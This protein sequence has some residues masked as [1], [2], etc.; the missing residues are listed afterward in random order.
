MDTLATLALN[1]RDYLQGKL[2]VGMKRSGKWPALRKHHLEM[3]P[4]CAVCGGKKFLEVHHIQD[5]HVHP[6]LELDPEN[7]ITLCEHPYFNDHL[8][9]GHLGDYKCI[10][11]NV[12]KDTKTWHEKLA[13]RTRESNPAADKA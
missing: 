10:N 7:L 8:R 11:D 13:N 1:V 5:F 12:V 2:S 3:H 4:T 6:E 9:Y